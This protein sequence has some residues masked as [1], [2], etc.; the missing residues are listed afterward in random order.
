MFEVCPVR[1]PERGRPRGVGV[2]TLTDSLM[3]P[4]GLEEEPEGVD[5]ARR[6]A[7][8]CEEARLGHIHSKMDGTVPRH[9]NINQEHPVELDDPMSM[10][11]MA[12]RMV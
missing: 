7:L 1:V 11:L 10:T 4:L 9:S 5:V 8:R 3:D 6:A 12:T 2:F